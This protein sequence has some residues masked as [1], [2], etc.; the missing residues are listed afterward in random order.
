MD[1]LITQ[2][3]KHLRGAWKYRWQAVVI[4]WLVAITGWIVVYKIPDT[5]E[6]S[7]R[8]YVDTQSILRPLMAGMAMSPNVEQQVS[9]MSRT[10]F[11]RP[12]V[13]RVMRMVDLDIKTNTVKDH[14]LFVDDLTNS[15]KIE[16]TGRNDLYIISSNNE[17]PKIAKDIVQALLTIFVEGSIGDKKKDSATAINFIDEQIRDY[18]GKLIAAE[19]ALKEFRRKNLTILPGQGADYA[20]QMQTVADQLDKA[21]LELTEAEQSRDSIKNQINGG[22]PT[23]A[24]EDG[25]SDTGNPEIDA[26]ISA[27]NNNLDT[28]RLNYTEL[29]P[30]VIAAKR[31]ITRLEA[32]KLEEANLPK[33][34][35]D[36][37]KNYSPM[38]QQLNVALSQADSNV[39]ALKARVA[40]YTRRLEALK[41][42]SNAILEMEANLSQMNRDYNVY[43]SNY[44]KL[45]ER[46]ETAK[47]SDS[48][49]DSSGLMTFRIIDPPTTPLVPAGPNRL[50]LFSL[51]FLAALASGLG[52]AFVMSQIRPA[53]HSQ[54]DLREITGLLVLGEVARIWTDQEKIKHKRHLYAFGLS[55]L[56]LL[57][58]YGLILARTLMQTNIFSF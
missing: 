6:S 47:I 37:G 4:A 28:L 49:G 19:T 31:L 22:E 54:G 34:N 30:D 12:N 10:L 44:E 32:R 29:H 7:A 38:L 58:L 41:S 1:E 8:I 20:A 23:L 43:K 13:E 57:V 40:E 52:V 48:L 18:E 11:S 36:P 56:V 33:N 24:S 53:F 9:I 25:T 17:N 35:Q 45:V 55:L 42:E 39:A 51:V 50:R 21:K 3:T 14:E 46:R 16:S 2:L 26:R 15:I 5:Y 27:L